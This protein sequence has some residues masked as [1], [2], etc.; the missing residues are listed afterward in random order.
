MMP[1]IIKA[2]RDENWEPLKAAIKEFGKHR[3]LGATLKD[4]AY[5]L[6]GITF[7]SYGLLNREIDRV[8]S[9]YRTAVSVQSAAVKLVYNFGSEEQKKRFLPKLISGDFIGCFGITEPLTG[10][11]PGSLKST[12][13]REGDHFVLNGTKTWISNSPIA[14]VF[15]IWAK[16]EA[17][18]IRGFI[19]EKGMPGLT[20]PKIEGK[21]SLRACPT[22]MVV[23]DNVKVPVANQLPPEKNKGLKVP[24]A[25]FNEARYGI[26]WG[27][28][29]AAE[30][31][32]HYA[33]NYTL[34]RKQFG[35]PLAAF[36][37]VQ[38]KLADMETEI[39]L[40]LL[41]CYQVGRLLDKNQ[42]AAEQISLIKRNSVGKNPFF[43]FIN[44][45]SHL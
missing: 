5:D 19:L 36:Q 24:F 40:A 39:S 23:M 30:F 7:V 20:A 27:A 21:L 8:D 18:D 9:G 1:D 28:I 44:D 13:K 22:G 32:F 10:S 2:Y 15:V 33:R 25:S 35:V 43:A 17:N 12:A 14:D 4:P 3:L 16:D 6:K 29:G 41:S 37:L 34:E 42:A 26:S 31:C 45:F 38:K 11:D